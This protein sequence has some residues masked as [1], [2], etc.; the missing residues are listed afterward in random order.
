MRRSATLALA[1]LASVA[2]AGC[3]AEGEARRVETFAAPSSASSSVAVSSAKPAKS[4]S[5]SSASKP[6][7]VPPP[8]PATPPAEL[9]VP[10]LVYHH[11]RPTSGYPKETWSYKMSVSPKVFEAQ[12]QWLLDHGYTTISLTTLAEMRAG[13]RL[14]PTKPVVV[15][16]DDNQM[17]AYDLALPVLVKNNQTAT[18]YLIT[19]RLENK[20]FV[21]TA[22]IPELLKD[23]MEIGS[24]T[25]THS[26]LVRLSDAQ[27]ASELKDSRTALEA[28]TGSPVLHLAYPLTSQNQRVRDAAQAAGYTT[29]TVMD[30]RPS[31]MKDSPWKLPRIMMTDDT[32]LA[33][34][35]P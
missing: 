14:G 24:H 20:D 32:N 13:T 18:F 12:M 26:D 31:T 33:K 27:L 10:I 25:V 34:V 5:K 19:N 35:L 1:L 6:A 2:L 4:L 29:A 17:S 9:T 23:G 8:A 22:Q 15:T 28:V 3:I 11:V 30:P 16:F 21:G 7:P